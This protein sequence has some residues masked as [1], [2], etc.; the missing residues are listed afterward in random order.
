MPQVQITAQMLSESLRNE[1]ADTYLSV[2]SRQSSN[3]LGEVMD[4]G[5]VT[6]VTREAIFGYIEAAPHMAQWVRGT[7]VPTESMGSTSFTVPV[8]D[9]AKR[10]SWHKHDRED[11]QTGT[12]VQHARMAGQ[13]AALL[14]ERMFIDL[15]GD[16]SPSALPAVPLA[17]DGVAMFSATDGSGADRFGVSGGNIVSGAGVTTSS[18]VLTDYYKAMVRLGLFQDGKGQPLHP[19]TISDQGVMIV[20]P[21]AY[22]EL[23]E[24]AFKQRRRGE[25]LGTDAG[26]TPSNV[27][28]DASRDVSMWSTSRL[29]NTDWYIFV[30]GMPTKPTFV[31]NRKAV[32]EFSALEGMNNSD[33]VRDTGEEYMQWE[34]RQG[35]GISLPYAAV[36]VN[37][38]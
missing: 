1:F 25:V 14:P 38:S 8:V 32:Q 19:D 36:K 2:Q 33:H 21:M 18:Q 4:L 31:L 7:S 29:T 3:M 20:Y 22:K 34:T 15:L 9:W 6:A 12:L 28:Q 23:F 11:E 30:K 24:E 5:G 26:V 17:G 27:I 10:V 35:A 37:N 16:A 13:S